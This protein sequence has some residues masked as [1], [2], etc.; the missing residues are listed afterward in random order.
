M[1]P[2]TLHLGGSFVRHTDSFAIARRRHLDL[3]MSDAPQV[4]ETDDIAGRGLPADGPV[5]PVSGAGNLAIG[6][7]RPCM[8]MAPI[9]KRHRN[10]RVRRCSFR[11]AA[12]GM[13]RRA[14]AD[15]AAPD[16]MPPGFDVIGTIPG[17]T[18]QDLQDRSEA[19]LAGP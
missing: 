14:P 4:P 13:G 12:G 10:L 2:V 5:K 17:M 3:R 9:T 11:L 19:E 6:M 1:Q 8:A 18:R 7:K 16:A 15:P